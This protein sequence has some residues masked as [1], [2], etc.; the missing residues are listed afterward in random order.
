MP[1]FDLPASL[2]DAAAVR[3][4]FVALGYQ[5]QEETFYS[6]RTLDWNERD[7]VDLRGRDFELLASTPDEFFQIL[8]LP[9]HPETEG[10]PKRLTLQL[11]R[12][13]ER[14][15]RE[16]IL[17]LP[18]Q[19]WNTFELVLLK[20]LREPGAQSG[21]P[22]EFLTFS[23]HPHAPQPHHLRALELLDARSVNPLDLPQQAVRAFRRAERAQFF[24]AVNFLSTYY[25]ERRIAGD[26]TQGV[27]QTWQALTPRMT[28][29]R[30][31][32]AGAADLPA[33]L[34]ALG[35][36]IAP[37]AAPSELP[38]LRANGADLAL[39]AQVPPD[40]ALDEQ[41]SQTS[42]PQIELLAALE[43]EKRR[44]GLLWGVLTNGRSWRLYSRLAASLSGAFYEVDLANLL[45][46]GGDAEL[47]LFAGFFGPQELASGFVQ[48]AQGSARTVANEVGENLKT[49]VFDKVF[50]RLAKGI[51][52]DLKRQ[53][54]YDGSPEQREL[55]R[56][57]TLILLY[58]ILFL[59]YAE[60][61][62]LLPTFF[63]RYYPHSL[64]Q[65][66]TE[67]ALQRFASEE[68][69]KPMGETA[70]WAWEWLGELFRM[71]SQGDPER[72]VP[73]YNGGLFSDGGG[74][75]TLHKRPFRLLAEVRIGALDLCYA[76]DWLGR[77]SDARKERDNQDAAR[78]LID[79]AALDVRR[80]GSIYEG[81]LEYQ[82]V[83]QADQELALL[84]TRKERKASGSY[85]TPDYIVAY[86]VEQAVGPLLEERERRFAALMP[87][88]QAARTELERVRRRGES[89]RVSVATARAN[90]DA[91]EAR[92]AALE[93]EA[94]E[95]LLDLKILDP[96]M[97]SGHF[98]V[99]AVDFVTDRLIGI[100]DRH[101][102]GNPIL[103]RLEQ[104]RG[105][106]RE[107][108]RE[109]GVGAPISDE[110]LNNVNL[111]RRLVMKRCV[112]GVDLNDMAV[113]LARLSLWLN[114]FTIGAPLSFLDHHLRWGNSLIGARVQQVQREMEGVSSGAGT[115][116]DMFSGVSAFKEMLDLAGF[117]EEL[118]E[119]A[120][121][122]AQ[123][124]EQSAA[125]YATYEQSVVPVKRLLDLW[126]SQSFGSKGA[127]ELISLYSGKSEEILKLKAALSGGP[128]LTHQPWQQALEQAA[129]LFAQH[130]FLHWDLE[131][132]EVFLDLRNK[133]WKSS[134]EAGFDAVVGNPPYD[135]LSEDE[136]GEEIEEKK[137]FSEEVIYREAI[138]YRVNLYRLFIA[139]S[140]QLT[141]SGNGG[142]HSFIVPMSLIGDRFT[143]DI[144]KKILENHQLILIEAFP[145]KDDPNNRVFPDAKL[146]TC[147]YVLR[148]NANN[149]DHFL[150]RTHP[151]KYI[152]QTSMYYTAN[153]SDIKR[154]DP[155]GHAIPL[156]S[157]DAWKLCLKLG[158]S[159]L[160]TKW[161][162]VAEMMTGDVIFNQQ[163]RKFL[164]DDPSK[165]LVLRGGHIQR[166]YLL[167]DPKQGSP[168]YI[169]LELWLR[170]SREGSSAYAH[171]KA[172]VV[173]QESAALDNW[174]RIIATYLPAGNVCGHKICYFVR[175]EYDHMALLSIFNSELVNW[176]FSI[177]ST[178]N[179]ISAYQIHSLP[180]PRIAF[181]TPEA[182]RA[183]LVE[184]ARGLYEAGLTAGGGAPGDWRGW[185][186]R[187][188]GLWAWADQRLSA[189]GGE[190]SD[191]VHDLLASLAE[192][193]IALHKQK[194]AEA[195]EFTGWLERETR[196]RIEDWKLKTVVQSFWEEPW[197]EIERALQRNRGE[198]VQAAGLR[199]RS[200]E[201]ALEPL[202]RAAQQRYQAARATLAPTTAAIA[203]TDRLIDLLVYRLYGL[204]DDEIDLVEQ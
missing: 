204:T 179:N 43:Q 13:L 47:R 82:L 91:A 51:A 69:R 28:A 45:E 76:L 137:Y 195:A 173:F 35:W 54:R 117:I 192:R 171:K 143:G 42:Y 11:Y 109:Q 129:A 4:L 84:H 108:L 161:H 194:Q 133:A 7:G 24:R 184:Q 191:A 46:F 167:E 175:S 70:F 166:Y 68:L 18:N 146:P 3:S 174:R 56:R 49:V 23:L 197:E 186:D 136:R 203:A 127:R 106:I 65:L 15:G 44:S 157:E 5:P 140:L 103:A 64:T 97:G 114:A 142:Y 102:E 88:L 159:P 202:V 122:N 183:G 178:T 87:A 139:R 63:S 78:R 36:Q 124:V 67:I 177:I 110:Q 38:R 80:L 85:Y 170:S 22:S 10:L 37:P 150:V 141:T 92:V 71:V 89:E 185:R 20:D 199:G 126:V 163:F 72:G 77:D 66:L 107:S 30:A 52:D 39:L 12:S 188:A 94:S 95:T 62:R 73:R 83:E 99:E 21:S 115:Q 152:E 41:V 29:L 145:Q 14:T 138:N 187:W 9:P 151:G 57:A 134:E 32:L 135:E 172:R 160:T 33:V 121:A 198:F 123:Q 40:R 25:L 1:S 131:F 182:E 164:T 169:D 16:A 96:A 130:R 149:N 181:T 132:P 125:L 104:I 8:L 55:I 116:L 19:R 6:A 31:A 165:T 154:F 176:R 128:P 193:M 93:H 111:L 101:K 118:V 75:D 59:L 119:I 34:A 196:S 200:A 48:Y 26:P 100:L 120:D 74:S 180:I 98:L 147:L 50:E 162:N 153:P 27:G 79:Y 17:I 105:Q 90:Q 61:M 112:Y 156:A 2:P 148:T 81:L 190:Q 58:R 60:S 158:L 86:I 201:A 113:E 53:E 144:R 189:P 168:V 155:D